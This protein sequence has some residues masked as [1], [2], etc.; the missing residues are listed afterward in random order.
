L[1]TSPRPSIW[2]G[3]VD[4]II[5]NQVDDMV[6]MRGIC[7]VPK[8]KKDGKFSAMILPMSEVSVKVKASLLSARSIECFLVYELV[9][10]RSESNSIMEDDQVF[11][12]VRVFAR[13]FASNCKVSVVMFMARRGQFTGNEDDMKRLKEGILQEHSVNSTYSFI[14]TIKRRTLRLEA[15]LHPGRQA[16]IGITLK[17]TNECVGNGPILFERAKQDK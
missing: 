11:I 1:L 13:P 8:G 14:C 3:E 4:F 12:A 10:Q 17:E 5:K 6:L 15:V 7:H 2:Y 16:M 9:K